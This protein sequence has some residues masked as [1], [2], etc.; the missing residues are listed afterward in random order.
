M[1][2][3]RAGNPDGP[4]AG[5]DRRD[6][7]QVPVTVLPVAAGTARHRKN[8]CFRG[9]WLTARTRRADRGAALPSAATAEG[10]IL[11][12]SQAPTAIIS[13]ASR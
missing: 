9:Q 5:E 6:D 10:R 4:A 7:A 2:R 1:V 11:S 8:R 3:V 12:S 13:A